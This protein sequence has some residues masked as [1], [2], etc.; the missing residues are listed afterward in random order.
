MGVEGTSG[1]P[2]IYAFAQGTCDSSRFLRAE[3]SSVFH[4]SNYGDWGPVQATFH[5]IWGEGFCVWVLS[6]TP[7]SSITP[8]LGFLHTVM[9]HSLFSSAISRGCLSLL[10]LESQAP[11]VSRRAS[12]QPPLHHLCSSQCAALLLQ[13]LPLVTEVLHQHRPAKKEPQE[14][15]AAWDCTAESSLW[16][17]PQPSS[18][19]LTLSKRRWKNSWVK[20]K[21]G[22][23][24]THDCH[25]QTRHIMGKI[26]CIVN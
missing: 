19:S 25:R 6:R 26:T 16:R 24:V 2:L 15:P 12:S 21:T 10:Q 23:S 9:D 7:W 13:L 11:L 5:C 8:L 14:H 4:N 3:F 17:G 18:C 22:T 20:I 1:D